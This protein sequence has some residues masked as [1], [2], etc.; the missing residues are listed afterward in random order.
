MDMLLWILVS[1]GALN[2]LCVFIQAYRGR[3]EPLTMEARAV[4]WIYTAG[5][6][7]WSL[8]LLARG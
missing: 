2:T 8:W 5:I 7:A 1:V 6:G 4:D 3:F